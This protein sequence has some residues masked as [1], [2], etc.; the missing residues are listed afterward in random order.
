MSSTVALPDLSFRWP[1]KAVAFFVFGVWGIVVLFR[2]PITDH[3]WRATDP[4]FLF[5]IYCFCLPRPLME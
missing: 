1:K 2:S 4:P 3:G 5:D